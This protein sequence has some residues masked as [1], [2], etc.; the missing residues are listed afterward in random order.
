MP[1]MT[2]KMMNKKLGLVHFWGM[3][4]FFNLTFFPMFIIGLLGQPRRVFTY[5][6][7]LQGLNDFSSVCAFLL[8]LSFLVFLINLVYSLYINPEKAS[9]NPWDSL[10]LEWQTATP[11]PPHNFDRIPVIMSDPYHY[12][13]ADAP[14]LA[15]FGQ[16]APSPAAS[17]PS[18]APPSWSSDE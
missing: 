15:D 12:S 6:K 5:A 13:E 10:G 8:G 2:G 3:F 11:I 17:S 18:G 16:K 1:K 4:I 14:P 7:S 9:S